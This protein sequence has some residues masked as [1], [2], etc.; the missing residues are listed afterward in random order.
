VVSWRGG[1]GGGSPAAGKERG[2][3]RLAAGREEA[4]KT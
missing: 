1:D 3:R 4:G 2:S